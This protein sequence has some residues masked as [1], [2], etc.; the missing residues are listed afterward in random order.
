MLI[1]PTDLTTLYRLN[2]GRPFFT[3]REIEVFH[4]LA[5]GETCNDIA[6]HL[7]VTRKTVEGFVENLRE[8]LNINSLHM[9]IWL[10]TRWACGM[11]VEVHTQ[12]PCVVNELSAKSIV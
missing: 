4:R 12:D 7:L 8:K 6:H 1:L 11:I 10:A 9:L 2:N 5:M 3:K